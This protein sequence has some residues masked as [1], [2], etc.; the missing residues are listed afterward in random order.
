VGTPP[1][2]YRLIVALYAADTGE[3][4]PVAGQNFVH[5]AQVDVQRGPELPV[6]IVPIQ[7]RVDRV[8]GPVTLVGYDAYPRGFAHA[9]E[10]PLR[11]GDLLHITFYWRAPDPLPAEWPADLFLTLQLGGAALTAPLAGGLYPTG[12]WPPGALVRGEFDIPYDGKALTPELNVAGASMQ[13]RRL[14]E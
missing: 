9:P 13:L 6:D 4:L 11:P 1:G 5:V 2:I 7:R 12:E 14:N 8:L 3:R 10:T